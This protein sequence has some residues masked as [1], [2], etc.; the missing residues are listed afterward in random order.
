[1][2]I[3]FTILLL[4]GMSLLPGC[5]QQHG[6][7]VLWGVPAGGYAPSVVYP[8]YRSADG[9]TFTLVTTQ[10]QPA[11]QWLDSSVQSKQTYWYYMQAYDT[12]T[13]KASA[14]TKTQSVA[15]P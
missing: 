12:V 6:G 8:I 5:P 2:R 15:I 7:L 14:P 13:G 9:T 1:M 11:T 3:G 10:M 4:L